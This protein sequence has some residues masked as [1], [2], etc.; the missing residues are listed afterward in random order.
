MFLLRLTIHFVKKCCCQSHRDFKTAF[1]DRGRVRLEDEEEIIGDF[2]EQMKEKE[3]FDD[4]AFFV[5]SEYNVIQKN[6]ATGH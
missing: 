5:E 4:L 2:N 6:I 3:K 1:I